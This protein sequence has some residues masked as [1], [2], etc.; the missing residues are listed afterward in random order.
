[1]AGIIT[2]PEF[3]Q[4]LV[5]AGFELPEMTRR[6]VIDIKYDAAVTVYYETLADKKMLDVVIEQLMQNKDGIEVKKIGGG[7]DG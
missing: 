6:V 3:C 4:K 2:S 7:N 1:M 5:D